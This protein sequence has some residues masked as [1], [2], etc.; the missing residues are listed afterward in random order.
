M[1]RLDRSVANK[2]PDVGRF[3]ATGKRLAEL[4]GCKGGQTK[5]LGE[6]QAYTLMLRACSSKNVRMDHSFFQPVVP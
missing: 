5:G 6:L 3:E 1:I 2:R 4:N